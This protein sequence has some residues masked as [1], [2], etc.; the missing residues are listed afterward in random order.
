MLRAFLCLDALLAQTAVT[1]LLLACFLVPLGAGISEW[2]F[3]FPFWALSLL[4][5]AVLALVLLWVFLSRLGAMPRAWRPWA[6]SPRTIWLDK[7][8]SS[9]PHNIP[10]VAPPRW[11]QTHSPHC[12]SGRCCIDQSSDDTKA[13]GVSS[14]GVFLAQCDNMVA[15]ASPMYFSR[16][17]WAPSRTCYTPASTRPPCPPALGARFPLTAPLCRCVYELATFC[18]MHKDHLDQ[19]LLLLSPTWPSIFNPFKS[20]Q[21]TEEELKPIVNFSLAEVQ[22]TMPRDR[23]VVLDAI[24]REWGSEAAF[25]SFVRTQLPKLLAVSKRRYSQQIVSVATRAFQMAFGG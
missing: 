19:R 7:C 8:A 12:V 11:R 22:C 24:R 3:S 10:M 5:L 21:L 16:L 9:R 23:A 13:A 6:L 25:E 20:A 15:F 14:F 1:T 4:P 2:V 18:R 17:W